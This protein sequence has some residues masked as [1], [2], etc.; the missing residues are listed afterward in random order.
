VNLCVGKGVAD[1]QLKVTV[2]KF[3]V[4]LESSTVHMSRKIDKGISSAVRRAKNQWIV[5]IGIEKQVINAETDVTPFSA[6]VHVPVGAI[7]SLKGIV[8][9]GYRQHVLILHAFTL[10]RKDGW[11]FVPEATAN[12]GTEEWTAPV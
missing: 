4:R 3:E 12:T 9:R 10:F 1:K 5:Q 2:L 6:V 8:I 11:R 7:T